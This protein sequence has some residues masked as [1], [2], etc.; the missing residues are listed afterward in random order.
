MPGAQETRGGRAS[1]TRTG[2]RLIHTTMEEDEVEKG[3]GA[4]EG[5]RA[6]ETVREIHLI[7]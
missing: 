3:M 4:K 7:Y 1:P 5:K 2:E 6:H